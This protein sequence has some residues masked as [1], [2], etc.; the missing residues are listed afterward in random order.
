MAG[1]KQAWHLSTSARRLTEL[2]MSCLCWIF[3]AEARPDSFVIWLHSWLSG[4]K[5]AVL[6]GA[7]LS[8][9]RSQI[10][11]VPKG[12]V[13]GPTL[14]TYWIDSLLVRLSEVPECRPFA[15]A[16]DLHIYEALL[17]MLSSCRKHRRRCSAHAFTW[18]LDHRQPINIEKCS[19]TLFSFNTREHRYELTR[20]LCTS[21]LSC[22]LM[23]FL[24]TK[25]LPWLRACV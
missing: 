6:R 12:S 13:L 14:W 25:P 1:V 19:A 24:E 16:D 10:L 21:R 7:S 2:L 8:H 20:S 5:F 17:K 11:G 18:S 23:L 3:S 4:R 15:F 22:G 9:F